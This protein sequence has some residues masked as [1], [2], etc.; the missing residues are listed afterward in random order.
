MFPSAHFTVLRGALVGAAQA[1]WV[2]GPDSPQERQ[3][4]GFTLIEE[5]YTELR[6]FYREVART[7]L[8]G[9]ERQKL[10]SQIAWCEERRDE[11]LSLR[12]DRADLNQT[13][14]IGWALDHRFADAER[15]E[16]GRLLWRQMSAD[17]HALGWSMFQRGYVV[18]HDHS[19]GLG[20]LESGGDLLAIAQP[21]AAAHELLKSGWSLFDRRCEG[22]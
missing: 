17:A 19:S 21:F 10:E 3:Q 9:Q 18:R 1:V 15:R 22:P 12:R 13:A 7:T 5:M 4:R 16:S 2:L 11:V 8:G 14:M 20:V 6:K